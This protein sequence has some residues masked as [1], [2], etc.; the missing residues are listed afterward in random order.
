MLTPPRER[1]RLS[2][3]LVAAWLAVIVASIPTARRLQE[4]VA[5]HLDRRLFLVATLGALAGAALLAG[6][7]LWQRRDPLRR[8][9][10]IGFTLSAALLAYAAWSLRANPEESLHVVEYG[11][12]GWLLLRACSHRFRDPGVYLL[13]AALGSLAGTVDEVLQWIV[14]DRYWDYRDLLINACAASLTLMLVGVGLRPAFIRPP[15]QPRTLAATC[16]VAAVWILILWATTWVTPDRVHRW[17]TDHPGL[18]FLDQSMIEFGYRHEDPEVGIF[19][20][21]LTLEELRRADAERGAAVAAEMDRYPGR[22][23]YDAFLTTHPPWVDTYAHELRVHLYRRDVYL[24]RAGLHRQ[25]PERFR[26]E[27]T[28]GYFEHRLVEKYFGNGLRHSSFGLPAERLALA[29]EQARRDAPYR[30]PVS[31]HLVTRWSRGALQSGLGLGL[32]ASVA[33][34]LYFQQRSRRI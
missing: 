23:G 26:D 27:L 20:S 29:R 11:F 18:A 21:R 14:P 31:A 4:W 5:A 25:D 6:R 16:R 1:E 10:R 7:G 3:L 22:R 33:A 17:V 30:S 9:Q 19:F 13:A 15:W 8:G 2:W 24:R 12:L 34:G 32:L 28:V